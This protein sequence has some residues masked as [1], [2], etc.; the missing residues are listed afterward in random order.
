MRMTVRSPCPPAFNICHFWTRPLTTLKLHY[1]GWLGLPANLCRML[2]LAS[3]DRLEAELVDGAIMLRPKKG[4]RAP[5]EP[6]NAIKPAVDAPAPAPTVEVAVPEK[7]R[8]G[9]PRKVAAT[10]HEPQ[11][12]KVPGEPLPSSKRKPGRLRKVRAEEPGPK[13]AVETLSQMEAQP[14]PAAASLDVLGEPWKLRR[15]ADLVVAT[16]GNDHAAPPLRHHN[17]A[18]SDTAQPWEERRPF[19]NVEIRKLGPGRTH[20]RLPQRQTVRG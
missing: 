3:G 17:R 7:L 15:K 2:D 16:E 8:P 5:A 9:R 18:K 20:N 13:S 14:A 11:L 6:Q 19:R 4:A 1:D 12:L 10:E